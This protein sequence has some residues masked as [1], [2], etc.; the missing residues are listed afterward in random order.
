M[1]Q[2]PQLQFIEGTAVEM[3][4]L[5]TF[6]RII[7]RKGFLLSL[8]TL[9]ITVTI[10]AGCS[11]DSD[12]DSEGNSVESTHFEFDPANFVDPTT[13]TN[14]YHPLRPGM[15]WIRT[16]TTEV[17]SREVPLVVI[18]TMT[19]VIRVIDGV[20]TVAMLDQSTD[21]GE[22]AQVGIDYLA[23]DKDGNV[24][25][26]GGYSE[27]YEGG[28]YTNLELAWLGTETGGQP[29]VLVPGVVTMD[30]PRWYVGTSGEDEDPTAGEPFGVGLDVSVEFG[31]FQN[32]TAILE[33]AE[34]EIEN[35]IKYY[36]PAVGVILNEPQDKSLHQDRF[37][38][39]NLIELSPEG[40]AEASQ[41]V[42]D[43]EAHARETAPD[44]FES[45]L[46]AT[47]AQ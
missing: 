14:E 29:G 43:L 46:P 16:G 9:L 11:N 45:A 28:E 13:S 21:S 4:Y 20:P 41:V 24:W 22:I 31:D 30:T 36:A 40:L 1:N 25:L 47:R 5:N 39:V 27:E 23:L 44:V 17:G 42:L 6:L 7:V 34:E 15:Q 26:M 18:S 32:V 12:S 38:L 2:K 3:L 10:I 33:G 8:I 19:D 37:E 35:E